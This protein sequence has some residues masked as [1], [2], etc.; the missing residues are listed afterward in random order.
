MDV[1]IAY[2]LPELLTQ[3]KRNKH[4]NMDVKKTTGKKEKS[5]KDT[6]T[7]SSKTSPK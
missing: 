4:G 7:P 5:S 1:A 2:E 3:Y 6:G